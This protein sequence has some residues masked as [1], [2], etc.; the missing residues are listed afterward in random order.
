[1]SRLN[2]RRPVAAAVVVLG[3]VLSGGL[4][5]GAG[6]VVVKLHPVSD[7]GVDEKAET[8]T[9]TLA[10]PPRGGVG[11]TI[12]VSGLM[13]GEHYVDFH[14]GGSCAAASTDGKTV[15]AGAAGGVFLPK[16][17]SVVQSGNFTAFAKNRVNM[18]VGSDGTGTIMY[19][20]NGITREQLAG[21]TIVIKGGGD[22]GTKVLEPM[23]VLHG[24]RACG[25][26]P[27]QG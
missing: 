11:V 3:C 19:F 17:A 10:E 24:A 23:V 25:V 20:V 6:D 14:E 7:K 12:V 16:G 22:E 13:Q 15:A 26:I 4:N 8:G 5:A 1:M 18:N 9:A 21:R 27:K 2:P